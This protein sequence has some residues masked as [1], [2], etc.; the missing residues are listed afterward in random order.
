MKNLL[1]G[2]IEWQKIFDRVNWTK[3]MY[4]LKEIGIEKFKTKLSIHG[5]EC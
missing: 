4:I 2:F 3:L 1:A 5:S